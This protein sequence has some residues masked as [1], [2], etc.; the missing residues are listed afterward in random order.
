MLLLH[1]QCDEAQRLVKAAIQLAPA[2]ARYRRSLGVVLE[3]A[4]QYD[5]AA[6]AYQRAIEKRPNDMQVRAV[7]TTKWQLDACNSSR[8]GSGSR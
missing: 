2:N 5:A 4:Q 1:L 3:A 6:D 8:G 7:V